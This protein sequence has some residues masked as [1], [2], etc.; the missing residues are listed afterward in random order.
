MEHGHSFGQGSNLLTRW[1]IP[2]S[3]ETSKTWTQDQGS[4]EAGGGLGRRIGSSLPLVSFLKSGTFH[5]FLKDARFYMK[6]VKMMMI[7]EEAPGNKGHCAPSIRWGL[8]TSRRYVTMGP[9]YI[10]P[11][12]HPLVYIGVIG[13]NY[14]TAPPSPK[15]SLLVKTCVL[16]HE[17]Q[18]AFPHIA[19]H[20]PSWTK[21]MA[22][23]P[24][25]V[26]PCLWLW[27]LFLLLCC[28]HMSFLDV[29]QTFWSCSRL[30]AFAPSVPSAWSVLF[31]M[32]TWLIYFLI[33]F[34]CHHLIKCHLLR[35]AL[36]D[37]PS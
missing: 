6:I 2:S 4:A 26:Q 13:W 27:F 30:R 1:W 23:E 20:V 3:P 5:Q 12:V 19:L 9:F 35:E 10:H 37:H 18:P 24:L 28:F 16:P 34:K 21:P 7:R 31:H 14:L 25:R 17:A 33:S 36:S 22:S 15:L 32:C 11:P 8:G 29:P